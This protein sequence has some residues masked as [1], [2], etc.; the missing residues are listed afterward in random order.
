MTDGLKVKKQWSRIKGNLG[1]I[2]HIAKDSLCDPE[3]NHF[4]LP[5]S[6]FPSVK[7]QQ[8][9]VLKSKNTSVCLG[10]ADTFGRYCIPITVIPG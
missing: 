4:D 10:G 3:Q 5:E 1:L 2:P 8:E 7:R 9:S 6:H